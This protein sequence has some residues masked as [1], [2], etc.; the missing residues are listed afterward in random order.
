MSGFITPS[1]QT[2]IAAAVS[3][4][5]ANYRK[6]LVSQGAPS[7]S[8][9]GTST[10]T[11]YP[12]ISLTIP[13]NSVPGL[14]GFLEVTAQINTN[15][16][17]SVKTVTASLGAQDLGV[18]LQMVNLTTTK[19]TIRIQNKGATNVQLVTNSAAATTAPKQTTVDMTVAQTLTILCN[20][21]TAGDTC[22]VGPVSVEASNA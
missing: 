22:N 7:A 15:N 9:T 3:A 16:S 11:N 17:G 10:S 5:V 21:N 4:G 13:A 20:L 19:L 12:V 2:S 8:V 6:L 18:T 14:N 1:Q